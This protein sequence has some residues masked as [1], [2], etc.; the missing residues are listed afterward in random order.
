M[1]SNHHVEARNLADRV[2]NK[3]GQLVLSQS[4]YGFEI[5]RKPLS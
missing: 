5:K 1:R 2:G 4:G 3:E